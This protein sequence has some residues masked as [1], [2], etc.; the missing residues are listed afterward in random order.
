MAVK[1]AAIVA[2]IVQMLDAQD[3]SG[4][5]RQIDYGKWNCF[6]G[7]MGRSITNY[8]EYDNI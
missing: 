1:T 7:D 5:N 2:K 3:E 6:V 8:I 4:T